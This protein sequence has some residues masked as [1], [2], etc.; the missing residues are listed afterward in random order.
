MTE[1][2]NAAQDIA[3]LFSMDPL[4]HTEQDIDAIIA[5]IR[6]ARSMFNTTGKAPSPV[7]PAASKKVKEVL[8]IDIG[9]LNL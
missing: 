6:E 4:K 9:D 7:K 2:L 3:R 5:K 1:P 8:D